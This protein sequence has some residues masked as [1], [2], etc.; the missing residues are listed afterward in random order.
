MA[1]VDRQSG[2]HISAVRPC[3]ADGGKLLGA[4]APE[5]TES[6]LPLSPFTKWALTALWS[7]NFIGTPA[8]PGLP[9]L[10]GVLPVLAPGTSHTE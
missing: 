7:R 10:T 2:G 8:L 6:R 4:E 3:P 1:V 9:G 5:T